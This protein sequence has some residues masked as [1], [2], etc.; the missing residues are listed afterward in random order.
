[1]SE[2]VDICIL[3]KA[4]SNMPLATG[5]KDFAWDCRYATITMGCNF[6]SREH[7]I[8]IHSRCVHAYVQLYVPLS[9]VMFLFSRQKRISNLVASFLRSCCFLASYCTLAMCPSCI[10]YR[11]VPGVSRVSLMA[12]TWLAGL[13][14][15]FERPSY[16]LS[17]SLSLSLSCVHAIGGSLPCML[18]ILADKW[19]WHPTC[20]LTP[21][22]ISIEP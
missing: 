5:S 19:S 14:V 4:A 21:W 9:L 13:A 3:V 15:L 7:P 18:P 12:H 17:L 16:V 20:V 1:M 11:Y 10:V 8:L 22:I 6:M 2:H